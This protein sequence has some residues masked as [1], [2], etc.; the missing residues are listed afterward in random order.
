M[1]N[2]IDIGR[3]IREI[4]EQKNLSQDKF[5][6]KIGKTGKTICAYERGRC[7]PPLRVLE[8]ISQVY[9][10]T[11]M[12]VKQSRAIDLGKKIQELKEILIDF[13][14]MILR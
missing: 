1:D 9:D 10:A 14:K 7:V 13:E 3:K 4:R 12:S 5:G 2:T 11:F 8:N 6:R